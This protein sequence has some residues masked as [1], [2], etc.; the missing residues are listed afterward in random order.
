V[1]PGSTIEGGKWISVQLRPVL[2]EDEAAAE[3][4]A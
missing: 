1:F 2:A 4:E 3:E